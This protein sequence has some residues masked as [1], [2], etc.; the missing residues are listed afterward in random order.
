LGARENG[1]EDIPVRAGPLAIALVILSTPVLAGDKITSERAA[2]GAIKDRASKLLDRKIAGDASGW[3]CDVAYLDHPTF[4]IMRLNSGIRRPYPSSNLL[5]WYAVRKSTG[6]V[7]YWNMAQ[8]VP[9][10]PL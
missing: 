6:Q 7:V 5:G 3:T 1:R 8:D 9:D 10:K 2:C 4:Y